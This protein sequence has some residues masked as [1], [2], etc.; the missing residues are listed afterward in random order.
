MS[1]GVFALALL[2]ELIAL[3]LL[4]AGLLALL[5]LAQRRWERRRAQRASDE[6]AGEHTR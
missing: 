4:G 5:D 1:V 2:A 3:C 6:H